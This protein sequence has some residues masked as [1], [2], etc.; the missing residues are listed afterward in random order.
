MHEF[1]I[2]FTLK[3]AF[4][5]TGQGDIRDNFQSISLPIPQRRSVIG[6]RPGVGRRLGEGVRFAV[7]RRS[8]PAR[9]GTLHT[10]GV[11][12]GAGEPA[13][14]V[15]LQRGEI[16]PISATRAALPLRPNGL[17]RRSTTR[18]GSQRRFHRRRRSSLPP[19][20]PRHLP[21][22]SSA[23]QQRRLRFVCASLAQLDQICYVRRELHF[24]TLHTYLTEYE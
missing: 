3:R 9:G 5:L 4:S 14:L 18:T 1:E 23:T 12:R 8:F 11:D 10:G 15:G 16:P 7:L 13:G 24:T 19:R 22:T 6:P 20:S 2:S 17:L 21:C